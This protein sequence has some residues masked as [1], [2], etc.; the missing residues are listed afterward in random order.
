MKKIKSF[1]DFLLEFDTTQQPKKK[2][3]DIVK[4]EPVEKI[5]KPEEKD[6]SYFKSIKDELL[7]HIHK[8]YVYMLKDLMRNYNIPPEIK[9]EW[10]NIIVPLSEVPDERMRDYKKELASLYSIFK[11]YVHIKKDI[12]HKEETED[13]KKYPLGTIKV[14]ISQGKTLG[15]IADRFGVP[16]ST[17][18]FKLNSLY[19]TS[20]TKLKKQ[21]RK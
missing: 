2:V 19:Q 20:Y 14:L 6:A 21:M 18:A 15:E 4:K 16:K 1:L 13:V 12:T 10:E 9:K 11:K 7:Q 17:L 8:R 3:Y 5:N